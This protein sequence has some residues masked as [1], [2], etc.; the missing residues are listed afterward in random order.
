MPYRTPPGG[1]PV[2]TLLPYAGSGAAPNGWLFCEG[3]TLLRAAYPDLFT[4]I[5][6]T[7]GNTDGTNFK[8]PDLQARVVV[9][10]KGSDTYF[11]ALG[12]TGGACTFALCVCHLPAH[13]HSCIPCSLSICTQT[14]N[15]CSDG[16]D[17][18]ALCCINASVYGDTNTGETGSGTAHDNLQPYLVLR[19]MIKATN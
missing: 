5:G 6:V 14:I 7:Y 18:S 15:A 1:A 12:C 2:G 8:L 10:R 3:A 17:C 11:P 4:A 16:G 9:G 19:Y 13:C